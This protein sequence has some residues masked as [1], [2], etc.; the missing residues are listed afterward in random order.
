MVTAW[1]S[2]YAV[3]T[4]LKRWKPPRSATIDGIAVATM[5]LS[6]AAMKMAIIA[7]ASTSARRDTVPVVGCFRAIAWLNDVDARPP[8]PAP[9][10]SI[11]ARSPRRADGRSSAGSAIRPRRW[12]R[13]GDLAQPLLRAVEVGGE[14]G[15]ELAGA[16][17]SR[18]VP[19]PGG[20]RA[21]G[22]PARRDLR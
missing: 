9:R 4:Q 21:C 11:A 17:Q 22:V 3:K 14:L 5:V 13:H 20:V 10:V 7:A 18:D 2:R 19:G 6:T 8:R 15:A 1:V 12:I 16:L